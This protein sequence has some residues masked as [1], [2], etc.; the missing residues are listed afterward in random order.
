MRFN[1]NILYVGELKLEDDVVAAATN[2][3]PC[4][5]QKEKAHK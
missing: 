4:N 3:L 5:D 1:R 2:K